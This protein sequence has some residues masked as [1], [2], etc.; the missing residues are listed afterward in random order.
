MIYSMKTCLAKPDNLRGCGRACAASLVVAGMVVGVGKGG[1]AAG[2]WRCGSVC[3]WEMRGG[4]GVGDGG[5]VHDGCVFRK[6]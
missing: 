2:W 5:T 4:G 3:V 1:W 6:D